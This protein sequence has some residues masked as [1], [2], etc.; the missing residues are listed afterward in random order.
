MR[1][2]KSVLLTINTVQHRIAIAGALGVGEQAVK[3][4]I[5]NNSDVLTKY[6]AF[7]KIKEITGLSE[8]EILEREPITT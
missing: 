7:E 4:A 6:A 8:D 5:K 3:N 2:N 1:I